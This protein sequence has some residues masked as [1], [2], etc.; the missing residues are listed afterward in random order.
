MCSDVIE[1]FYRGREARFYSV[2]SCHRGALLRRPDLFGDRHRR[3]Y[4]R[5]NDLTDERI[6]DGVDSPITTNFTRY[7]ASLFE[8]RKVLRDYR[9]RLVEAAPKIRYTRLLLPRDA[10]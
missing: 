8:D 5:P 4:K 9:L 2:N 7:N 1:A 10:T 3:V 6:D